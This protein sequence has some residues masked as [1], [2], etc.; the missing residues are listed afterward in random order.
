MQP[1]VQAQV[2]SSVSDEEQVQLFND[3]SNDA[4]SKRQSRGKLTAGG[5]SM[6]LDLSS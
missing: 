1:Q 4:H 2:P 3:P 5:A 6:R